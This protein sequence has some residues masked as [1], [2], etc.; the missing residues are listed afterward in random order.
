MARSKV[1]ERSAKTRKQ[2]QA[3]Q[4]APATTEDNLKLPDFKTQAF[5][6]WLIGDTPLITHAWS[7]KA[8]RSMLDKQK[9]EITE[10]RDIRDP[11][12]DFEDS[13]YQVGDGLYGFPATAV[14]KAMLQVA[15]KDRGVA[16]ETMK[17][18][19]F[20]RAPMMQTRPALAGARCDMPLFRIWGSKP[21]M[22]EDMVRVGVGLSKTATLAYRGQFTRW[23]IRV[24]G[25]VNVSICPFPWVPFTMKHSGLSVGIGDWRNEKSGVFGAY[26]VATVEETEAWEEFR[27]SGGKG[28]IPPV[29][30]E[31][32]GAFPELDD[33]DDFSEAA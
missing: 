22:R 30:T 3:E 4:Q 25:F 11:E 15:H 33:I 26:H 29:I 24:T 8:K 21:E 31:F 32:G 23:A 2:W 12:R 1:T 17:G 18:A 16:R 20:L 27:R 5:R 10:G 13:L 14:K 19:L 9:K 6:I 28:K 7:E